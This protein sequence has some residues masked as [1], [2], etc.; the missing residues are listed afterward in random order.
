MEK[1]V[2]TTGPIVDLFNKELTQQE[3]DAIC[4]IHELT[5]R[6]NVGIRF[7]Y[8]KSIDVRSETCSQIIDDSVYLNKKSK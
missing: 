6:L 8:T 1:I 5:N 2:G 4:L 7:D 3:W